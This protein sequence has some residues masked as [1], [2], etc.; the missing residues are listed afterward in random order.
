VVMIGGAT[1]AAAEK[2]MFRLNRKPLIFGA[3]ALAAWIL[4]KWTVTRQK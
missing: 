1:L 4:V 3:L 2:R